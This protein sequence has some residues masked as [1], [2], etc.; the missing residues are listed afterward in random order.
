MFYRRLACVPQRWNALANLF[1]GVARS[2]VLWAVP[3][4]GDEVDAE[5]A[6]DFALFTGIA[7]GAVEGWVSTGLG[8]VSVAQDLETGLV[9]IV[10]Q[11]E[12]NAVV[13]SEV[14]GGDVLPVPGVVGEGEGFGVENFQEAFAATAVLDIRPAIGADSRHVE[15]IALGDEAGLVGGEIIVADAGLCDAFIS[16]AGAIAAL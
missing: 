1:E 6:L 3:V 11:K 4:K 7:D 16:G 9:R 2:D 8:H 13:F 12:S 10:H 5:D 14:A 15:G